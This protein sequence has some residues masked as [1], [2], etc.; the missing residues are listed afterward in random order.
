[1]ADTSSY[2]GWT[3]EFNTLKI[4]ATT[5]YDYFEKNKMIVQRKHRW[6]SRAKDIQRYS[7]LYISD[8]TYYHF[9]IA[10]NRTHIALAADKYRE[11]LEQTSN[12]KVDGTTYIIKPEKWSKDN[13]DEFVEK[14]KKMLEDIGDFDYRLASDFVTPVNANK[15]KKKEK[16]QGEFT[17]IEIDTMSTLN[18]QDPEAKIYKKGRLSTA[19]ENDEAYNTIYYIPMTGFTPTDMTDKDVYA[20]KIFEYLY[21]TLSP[22]KEGTKKKHITIIG[23]PKG[24]M[25]I[26]ES[27]PLYKHV[28]EISELSAEICV[29]DMSYIRNVVNTVD[30]D[31][32]NVSLDIAAWVYSTQSLSKMGTY[33][34]AL[35][36]KSFTTFL[37]NINDKGYTIPEDLAEF[38]RNMCQF[39]IAISEMIDE[40]GCMISTESVLRFIRDLDTTRLLELIKPVNV[41]KVQEG[42]LSIEEAFEKYR[43]PIQCII[44]DSGRQSSLQLAYVEYANLIDQQRKQNEK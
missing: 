41:L 20:Y 1:M 7:D 9:L 11:H 22:I 43:H 18:T 40:D 32:R 33:I 37:K 14:A 3:R 13:V 42:K 39:D 30:S 5:L 38:I 12:T 24:G 44:A 35:L 17:S 25:D 31:V 29:P 34:V 27:N 6:E 2:T 8:K 16:K 28:E 19:L 21:Y 15:G 10:D 4:P 36:D 26:V 23:V